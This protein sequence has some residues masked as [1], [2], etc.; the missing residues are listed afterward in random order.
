MHSD[1]FVILT[2]PLVM[3]SAICRGGKWHWDVVQQVA[4]DDL[5]WGR[6]WNA[7]VWIGF[8]TGLIVGILRVCGLG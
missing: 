4:G 1:G 6:T 7:I 2:I 8:F 5:P 3:L